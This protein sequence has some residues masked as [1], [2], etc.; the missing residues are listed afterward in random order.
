MVTV[1]VLLPR[2]APQAQRRDAPLGESR[3]AAA[4]GR[5]RRSRS[6]CSDPSVLET[7]AGDRIEVARGRGREARDRQAHGR[8]PADSLRVGRRRDS[9]GDV[10]PL[11]GVST[12]CATAER[13]AAPRRLMRTTS[14]CPRARAKSSATTKGCRASA[15][16]RWRS[17]C[18][19]RSRC[20]RRR[21]RTSGP[22]TRGRSRPTRRR[23]RA[24][25]R[26]V[27]VEVWYDEP[28]ERV[29]QRGG[30]RHRRSSGAS[31]SAASRPSASCAT[32]KASERRAR[33]QNLVPPLHYDEET[34]EVTDAF[35]EQIRQ[36]LAT[37][38]T[39]RTSS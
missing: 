14:R 18:S 9:P 31:R 26:R 17:S 34:I 27:E 20:R 37:S 24:L 32:W 12:A 4:A 1:C 6:G 25:N 19:T 35:V 36:A 2:A 8:R 39:S 15:P 7:Q 3:R 10:E 29:A 30:A 11:R 16:A 33:V 38:A 21:S 28:K 22:A 5:R 23:G 13:A